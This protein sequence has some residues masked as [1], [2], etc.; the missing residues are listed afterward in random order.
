MMSGD[1][2][3]EHSGNDTIYEANL[4]NQLQNLICIVVVKKD[5]F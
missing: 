5:S 1:K 3:C 4:K 2:D